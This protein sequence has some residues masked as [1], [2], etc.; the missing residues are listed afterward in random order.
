[1]VQ[2]GCYEADVAYR[3]EEV[4]RIFQSLSNKKPAEV[5]YLNRISLD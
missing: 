3:P 2:C 5:G 4:G 1:M